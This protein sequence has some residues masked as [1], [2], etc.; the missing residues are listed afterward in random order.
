MRIIAPSGYIWGPPV[1][2]GVLPR[3]CWAALAMPSGWPG[4]EAARPPAACFCQSFFRL[5]FLLS[6]YSTEVANVVTWDGIDLVANETYILQL[7]ACMGIARAGQPWLKRP[8]LTGSSAGR[9]APLGKQCFLRAAGRLPP[10]LLFGGLKRQQCG[11][12]GRL[13]SRTLVADQAPWAG[14]VLSKDAMGEPFLILAISEASVA[15]NLAIFGSHL[16]PCSACANKPILASS[17]LLHGCRNPRK[18]R[19]LRPALACSAVRQ[20]PADFWRRGDGSMASHTA[21]SNFCVDLG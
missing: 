8:A 18:L 6:V 2:A 12:R 5:P 7:E 17:R 21:C 13:S 15:C 10:E 11:V 16:N 1:T 3:D 4:C 19:A 20:C 14:A 9:D